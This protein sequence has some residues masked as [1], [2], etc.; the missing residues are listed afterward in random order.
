MNK[1][2]MFV[3]GL[4]LVL[5]GLAAGNLIWDTPEGSAGSDSGA[6]SAAATEAAGE[7]ERYRI[8]VTKA[9]P[10][11][12]PEDALVTIVEVSDFE[13]PFCSR[14]LPTV[15]KIVKEY[16]GKVRVVWRNNPLPFHK[17]A[18]PAAQLAME[19]FKQGGSK[20][21]W[22]AHDLLFQNQKALGRDQLIA[23]AGKLELN[24]EAFKKALDANA[25]VPAIKAD[26]ALA[27]KFDARGTPA[28]FINGR[29]LMGAQPLAEF[30]KIVD[31]EI[32]RAQKIVKSGT[33]EKDVYAALMKTAATEVKAAPNKAPQKRR[34]PDPNAVY[35]VPVGEEP[36]KGPKD[37]LVTIVEVSDFQ[38][39]FC[40]RV[41]GT[42]KQ[43][44]K[45]YG[46]KVRVVWM[47]NPL[48]FHKEALPAAQLA[49]E[50]HAQGGD[51]KF[52]KMHDLLFE[53]QRKL[54][55][56]DLE[57]YARE[58][59]LN[60]PKVK[61]A[62]D[63]DKYK[64]VI[65]A[66]QTLVKKLGAT[67]TPSFFIN[68]R[69][70]RG[71]QPFP[72]FKEVIDAELKK[73]EALIAAG[74]PK[75]QVYAKTIEKGLTAAKFIEAPAAPS[76]PQ[77]AR[78]DPNKVYKIDLPKDVPVAGSRKAKVVI[79][80]FSDFQ[81]PFC[82]RVL[83]SVT[84]IKETY[85]DKVAIVWRH[86]PL[87]FHQA[88]PLAHEASYEIFRQKGD[89]AFWKY[90]DLL[91]ANQRELGEDKLVGYAEKIGG[92]DM[93]A[94]KTALKK[95]THQARI[96]ADMDAVAKAGAR[97]GTPSFFIN[98]KLIQGAQPFEAFKAAIDAALAS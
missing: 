77:A 24:V 75:S 33:A 57:G 26:Q 42:L 84:K 60:L 14:V 94:F 45:E 58:A 46:N 11:K 87:P 8:P 88:A 93:G 41:L 18:T 30:K 51:K 16:A 23:Y 44:E 55:R 48:P 61:A 80:E 31:D 1:G 59:G 34:M 53:N 81:C 52:W 22:E 28:F 9:Q 63:S 69:N 86:Y 82:S 40:S 90:H 36:S 3:G 98:G 32:A 96:K 39:P 13:C 74:T 12:G 19:A 6:P 37:A 49:L 66:Q 70:L 2:S 43:I 73:A 72:A 85:G 79:Q 5:G 38:C 91:F 15:D 4:L 17:N 64:S 71:A 92:V 76:E 29:K 27:A 97:I 25:H 78:P 7:V 62:L 89:E 20:K 54:S 83:P 65:E 21:F 35:K 10:S 95:R 68:G 50:A 56:E 47:N 67:G